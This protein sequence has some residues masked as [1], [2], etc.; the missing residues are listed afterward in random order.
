MYFSLYNLDMTQN[1]IWSDDCH[2]NWSFHQA[3]LSCQ[4]V[5]ETFSRVNGQLVADTHATEFSLLD[6]HHVNTYMQVFFM[7]NLLMHKHLSSHFHFIHISLISNATPPVINC[8]T[9]NRFVWLEVCSYDL[10]QCTFTQWQQIW[11]NPSWWLKIKKQSSWSYRRYIM[12]TTGQS[13][14][15][16]WCWIFSWVS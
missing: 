13:V 3:C 7:L 1:F 12:I 10:V 14:C 11:I 8:G 15:I 16:W 6:M 5:E 2:L 9:R 4:R